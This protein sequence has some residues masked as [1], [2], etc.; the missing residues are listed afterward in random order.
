MRATWA[1]VGLTIVL[2]GLAAAGDLA[3]ALT[4]LQSADVLVADRAVEEIVAE[5]AKGAD[6]L[7]PLLSD[8][9]RDV[10]AG[11]IRGLGLLR[12]PRALAPLQ[13]ALQASLDRAGPD[14]MD[15]RYFRILEVQ[16]LGR[17]GDRSSAPLL[18]ELLGRPDSFER[19]HAA[20]SLFLSDED[21]GYSLARDCLRDSS[22]AIRNLAVQ[23]VGEAGPER[24]RALVVPMTEDESWV[25]RESA[26]RVLLM[27]PSDEET[28]QVL[29]RGADDPSWYV[30]QTVAER[31]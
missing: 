30:R 16:A 4:R 2:P 22:M 10:R 24:A 8:A 17:I 28:R 29:A 19:A 26:F 13:E 14:T 27:W 7:L 11:S 3:G 15:D 6:A 31:R 18:R 20:I 5:G 9:R 1:A 21:P 12:E 23:G 25:V